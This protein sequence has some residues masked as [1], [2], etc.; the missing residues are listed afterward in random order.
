[1]VTISVQYYGANWCA[2]CKAAKP[3]ITEICKKFGIPLTQFDYDELEE[4]KKA[5]ISKLPTVLIRAMDNKDVVLAEITA[6]HVAAFESWC[7]QNVR[8]IPSDD[9]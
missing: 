3:K 2:P 8:V 9:F 6:N 4:E 5:N 7:S 1:M